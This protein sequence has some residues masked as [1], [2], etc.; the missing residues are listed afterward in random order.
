MPD[1]PAGPSAPS[2]PATRELIARHARD[3]FDRQGYA[4]TS[5]RAIAAAAAIDPA[6]VIRY[7]GSK[8]ELFL[9]VTGLADYPGP[10]L[11]G[12]RATLGTRLVASVLAPERAAMRRTFITM[13]QASGYERVR[14][15]LQENTGRLFIG[16]LAGILE[17][18]DAMLR[19]NLVGAQILGIIQAWALVSPDNFTE[20]DLDRTIDLYGRSVQQLIDA[21]HD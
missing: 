14:A 15:S 12:P 19:A 2:P 11:Q 1:K 4:A 20:V 21:P 6:L 13:L 10:E 5:V 17:G 7:F 8:E 3:M 16:R 18:P 9:H